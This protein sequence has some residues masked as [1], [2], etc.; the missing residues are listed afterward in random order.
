MWDIRKKGVRKTSQQKCFENHIVKYCLFKNYTY[1]S[2][3]FGPTAGSGVSGQSSGGIFLQ[4]LMRCMQSLLHLM[5]TLHTPQLSVCLPLLCAH[6][7]DACPLLLSFYVCLQLQFIVRACCLHLEV[8][9]PLLPVEGVLD[10]NSATTLRSIFPRGF[11]LPSCAITVIALIMGIM[12]TLVPLCSRKGLT[13]T[14]IYADWLDRPG[15]P[16][17]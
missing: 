10:L 15:I 16:K 12:L 1:F 9:V 13:L 14:A 11:H 5:W 2:S 17:V 4:A 7:V 3:L 6:P 8:A